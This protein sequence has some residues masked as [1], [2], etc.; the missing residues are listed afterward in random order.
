[1]SSGCTS[2]NDTGLD[3]VVAAYEALNE[4]TAVKSLLRIGAV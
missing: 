1:M 4:R 3:G 2:A